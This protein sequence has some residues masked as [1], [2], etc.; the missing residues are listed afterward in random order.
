VKDFAQRNDGQDLSI[1]QLSRAFG[2]DAGR[3]K[4]ALENDLNDPKVRG[5][6][7]AFDDESEIQILEWIRSQAE[8][9]A[10]VTR[11]D[12]RHHCNVKYSRS[13]SRRWVDSFILR[14]KADLF[15]TKSTPQEDA[16][17]EVPRAFLDEMVNYLREHVQ[18]IKSELVFNLDEVGM[19]ECRNVG[20]S[21]CRNGRIVK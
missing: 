15:E 12:I 16:R 10:P 6:H 18:G 5:R 19:S 8:K 2:C 11:T 17:L 21:E 3:V 1:Y 20:M 14:H 4:A 13:I 7:F 9:C